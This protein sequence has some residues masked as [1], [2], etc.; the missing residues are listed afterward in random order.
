MSALRKGVVALLAI[1]GLAASAAPASAD[2]L[3]IGSSLGHAAAAPN[4]ELCTNCVGIQRSQ[5]GGR[6]TLPLTSP[7]NGTVTTWAVRTSDV[8]AV[9]NLRILRPLGSS[10][11]TGAGTSPAVTV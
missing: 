1:A 8:G 6:S 2:T 7:A 3:Q 4:G 10:V 11:Y 9:Y 5:A